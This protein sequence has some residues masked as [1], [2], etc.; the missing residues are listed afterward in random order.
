MKKYAG[1]IFTL[2]LSTMLL[3]GCSFKREDAL[4]IN[5]DKKVNYSFVIT[6]D[7]ELIDMAIRTEKEDV[8]DI[9]EDMRWKYVD[10]EL[11]TLYQNWNKE[12][13]DNDGIKGYKFTSPEELDIDELVSD[14]FEG[15]Y[16]L[17]SAPTFKEGKLFTKKDDVYTSFFKIDIDE[18]LESNFNNQDQISIKLV[19]E[20]PNKSISNNASDV[21]KDGKTLTWNIT[22]STDIDFSFKFEKN[23]YM[24]I[25]II[26]GI[27]LLALS[28]VF[29]LIKNKN[30]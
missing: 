4:T 14:N 7:D 8:E 10:N 13:I 6:M 2:I 21:S 3:T 30:K 11:T 12:K 18:E 1:I 17:G 24:V 25:A 23:N 26:G 22:K 16:V 29:I 27:C 5:K 20:L 9:S 28:L 19:V 15:R